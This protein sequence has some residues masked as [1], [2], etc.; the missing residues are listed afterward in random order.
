M[1]IPVSID[2]FIDSCR[3]NKDVKHILSIMSNKKHK[4]GSKIEVVNKSTTNYLMQL[5]FIWSD[6]D[7]D[8]LTKLINEVELI[9][10]S[11]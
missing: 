9:Y 8:Y 2:E 6:I 5:G 1:I 3:K 11:R 10:K 7:E 4:E